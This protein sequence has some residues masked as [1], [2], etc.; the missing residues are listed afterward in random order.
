MDYSIDVNDMITP[1][2]SGVALVEDIRATQV[3][4]GQ[5]A[6]WWLGQSGYAIKMA[7]HLLYFDL[8]LSEHLT[9]KYAN[10]EKPHVRITHAPL[11]GG[12]L[13][14]VSLVFAS[15]KH[16]DHLDPGTLPDVFSQNSAARLILPNAILD[17]AISIGINR[18]R[19]IP[20]QG[21]DTRETEG[22][23][24]HAIPSAHPELD[25]SEAGYPFL[26]FVVEVDGVVFYH[27]GDTLVYSGLAERLRAFALDFAFLPI[28]GTDERRNQL[29]V[30]PNMNADEALALARQIGSPLII[31]H[32]YDMFTFNT[33]DVREFARKADALH[34]PYRVLQ[35]GEKHTFTKG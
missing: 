21:D 2:Q 18:D 33:A 6:I 4:H 8:Y 25:Y 34:L 19:L 12:D 28:N 29:H 27:S 22:V 5:A 35:C 23:T 14:D 9:T 13:P 24:I 3:E 7:A 26:G 20:M 17:H 11:R 30:P 32:H 10:T 15:H 16:S 31:P 1:L